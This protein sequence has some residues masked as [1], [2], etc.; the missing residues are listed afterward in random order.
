MGDD[1]ENSGP[2]LRRGIGN[3]L[4][5]SLAMSNSSIAGLWLLAGNTLSITMNGDHVRAVYERVVEQPGVIRP[6]YIEFQ[7]TL[8]GKRIVGRDTIFLVIRLWKF[9]AVSLEG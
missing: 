1:T 3:W 7:G 2:K 8:S 9:D 6:G 4:S 5:R